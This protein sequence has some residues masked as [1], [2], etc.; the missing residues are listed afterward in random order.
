[1]GGRLQP[2]PPLP[3]QAERSQ[4]WQQ[5]PAI[6]S[7]QESHYPL[8]VSLNPALTLV[9]IPFTELSLFSWF[10]C[11]LFAAW[12]LPNH[13]IRMLR[14]ARRIAL[15]T[16]YPIFVCSNHNHL[17]VQKVPSN[18]SK[19]I[20]WGGQLQNFGLLSLC[21]VPTQEELQKSKR[22]TLVCFRTR[23][24]APIKLDQRATMEK[25]ITNRTH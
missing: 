5:H 23:T 9:C 7:T 4:R 3:S 19:I 20:F 10:E 6:V 14:E 8:L 2:P 17:W 18:S 12:T 24:L 11:H 21:V 13:M 16:L 15:F 25:L 22:E 1:M